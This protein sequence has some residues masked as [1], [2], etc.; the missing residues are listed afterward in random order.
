ML[1]KKLFQLLLR[2]LCHF[3]LTHCQNEGWRR[4][5]AGHI[6]ILYSRAACQVAALAL[7]GKT[8]SLTSGE[9]YVL[10]CPTLRPL[11]VSVCVPNCTL[12]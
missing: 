6:S 9:V 11:Y 3:C 4:G 8:F 12:A 5:R 1:A 10:D 7:A 2:V